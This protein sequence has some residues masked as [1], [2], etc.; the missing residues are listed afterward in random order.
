MKTLA[1]ALLNVSAKL[2]IEDKKVAD[3]L[4]RAYDIVGQLGSGYDIVKK[5]NGTYKVYKESTLLLEDNSV[6]Y[7]IVDG[8]CSCPDAPS[9]RGNMCKH[10]LAVML[11]EEMQA[12]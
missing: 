7:A 5:N 10:R 2:P 8:M 9:A 12:E 3:R 11:M 6:Y 4:G 1:Q